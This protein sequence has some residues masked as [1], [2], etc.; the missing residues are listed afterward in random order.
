MWR[1]LVYFQKYCGVSNSFALY[2]ATLRN[3]QIA[4]IDDRTGSLEPGKCADLIV[5]DENPL[6]DL[7]ALRNVRMVMTRGKLLRAPHVKKYPNVER[8][9]DKFL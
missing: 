2:T 9:L 4:H 6:G 1:E 8:E 5:T 3:A 7:T